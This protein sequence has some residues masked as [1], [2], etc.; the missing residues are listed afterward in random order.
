M[1]ARAC[2][3][4][5][6]LLSVI[7]AS[8]APAP[9]PTGLRTLLA[10][11]LAADASV[12][13]VAMLSRVPTAA[14][15][16]A[17]R[18]LGLI[19]QPMSHLPMVLTRG[20]VAQLRAAV[21]QGAARDVYRNEPLQWFSRE[22][23]AAMSADAA[24]RLGFDGAGIGIAIVD[25]GIDAS[26][27]DLA[28]RVVRNVRVYGP[29]Y[30]SIA[31]TEQPTGLFFPA[32][33]SLVVAFDEL[34]YN[35]T[36]TIGH[37]THVAGIA[38]GDGSGNPEIVGVAPGA[39]LVGY[40][41]GEVLFIFTAVASFNDI[42]A[43]REDHN[44]RV[45]NNS[46]GSS[47][48]MFDPNAPINV[49]SKALH[50]AG[51]TVVFAAG[52]NGDEMTLNPYAMA[53]WVIAVGSS[54][55]SKEKSSF[56][57]AGLMFDNSSA[58]APDAEGHQHFEGDALGLSFPDVSAPGTAILSAGT[59]TGVTA[60]PGTAPGGA[61]TLQGTSMAAP[62]IAGLAAVLLQA[63]PGLTP[64]QVRLVMQ[65]TS[66]PMRDGSPHWK[67]G[68]GF[69][70]A[71][72]AVDL[73]RRGDFSPGM[74]QQLQAGIEKP[75]RDARAYRALSSDHWYFLQL[76]ATVAGLDTRSFTIE[77]GPETDA[78][79]AGI[80]F[81]ADAG[82]VGFNFF[83][84]W[85]LA[86]IDPDG[87]TVATSAL[88]SYAVSVLHADFRELGL[89]PK[90]GTWT[91]E[92]S[93]FLN[94]TQPALLWD[95]AVTVAVTQLHRQ[96][97]AGG[98]SGPIFVPRGVLTLVLAG[99]GGDATSPEGCA[100]DVAGATGAMTAGAPDADCRAGAVGYAL[101]YGTGTPASFISEPIA[102]SAVGGATLLTLYLVNESEPAYSAAFASGLTYQLDAVD[103]AGQVITAI[104]GGEVTAVVGGTPTLG[105]YALQIPPT[106]I[107]PGARLRLNLLFSGFYSSNMRLLWGGEYGASGIT[108]TTGTIDGKDS[109]IGSGSGAV[110][111]ALP[112]SLLLPLL[113]ALGWRRRRRA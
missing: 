82:A 27:P 102:A 98:S 80:A 60:T 68:Y 53:P 99:G 78:I 15:V 41:T 20:T 39:S 79:H 85:T 92:A 37:G 34:P 54:T 36:D 44:V 23:N 94:V 58:V 89:A 110:V 4:L 55:V 48:R 105:E 14:D 74:L 63:R 11:G 61:A 29:E 21:A 12:D 69:A 75:V 19:A 106:Q 49:A 32:E 71:K 3:L 56:S 51:L 88:N 8:A 95:Q 101:N 35:N 52:N 10:S 65:A 22:S 9:A 67:S 96:T 46:W 108:L 86:L 109:T 47:Y 42:L 81:P 26:H 50:D 77:V 16:A 93:G 57:S 28:N 59:P 76:P 45:V 70:D 107:P 66:V 103:D 111:G 40:S 72:R 6:A 97:P 31:G 7:P 18:Q 38:A 62:H 90:P 91:V 33:P 1:L 113:A 64:E 87:N 24:H 13:A 104:A 30:L 5:A 83:Y 2:L 25:S 112:G 73:V 43:T 17:L 84:E 100:Y